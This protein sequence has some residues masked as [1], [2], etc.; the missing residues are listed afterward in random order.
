MTVAVT[1]HGVHSAIMVAWVAPPLLGGL[2]G[3]SAW[4]FCTGATADHC[5]KVVEKGAVNM[6]A[7]S[8]HS[9]LAGRHA[10]HHGAG[11]VG[12]LLLSF[13]VV[14]VQEVASQILVM[15]VS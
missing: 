6:T 4:I 8:I 15:A 9:R 3:H 12:F 14:A 5:G 2:R 1:G 10:S 11:E 7:Q 13:V